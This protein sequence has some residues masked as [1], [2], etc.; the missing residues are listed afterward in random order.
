M[1]TKL[2]ILYEVLQSNWPKPAPKR[3]KPYAYNWPSMLL[4]FMV[5]LLKGIHSYKAMARYAAEHYRWFGWSTAPSRKTLARRFEATPPVV[6]RLMPLIAHA[7]TA[8]DKQVFAFRWAFIDKSVFRA[9]GGLWHRKHRLLGLVPHPSIDTEAS[10][11]KSA[12]HGWRFGYGLHLLCNASRFPLACTV[13][14]AAQ[15]DTSQVVPLLVHFAEYLGV[16]VAD[17]GYVALKLL[18]QLL[19][20]WKVFMLLPS[21]FTGTSLS[22]WQQQY[23][24]L[25]LT[26]Q[27]RWLY[28]QRK[29]SIEPVFALIKELFHL[30]GENQLPYRGLAKVKPYLMMTTLT[31]QLMMYYNY[32]KGVDLATTQLF[33]TDFK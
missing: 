1:N 5:M 6:Y 21:R 8:L 23:N 28:R 26:P 15:K 18:Q 14:T 20:C 25:V 31:V 24:A 10:W 13:T 17:A 19:Q 29:P 9:K 27:A 4:F 11:A 2:A 30:S 22:E 7:A 3:G 16:V 33:L 12:Y 32:G